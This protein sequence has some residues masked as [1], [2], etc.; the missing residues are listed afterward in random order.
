M[1]C[2]FTVKIFLLLN[3][4]KYAAQED[5]SVVVSYYLL[6]FMQLFLHYLKVIVQQLSMFPYLQS[7]LHASLF[8]YEVLFMS[9][10]FSSKALD[11]IVAHASS[12]SSPCKK[13]T[14]RH[15]DFPFGLVTRMS[16]LHPPTLPLSC[17]T[18]WLMDVWWSAHPWLIIELQLSDFRIHNRHFSFCFKRSRTVW[19]QSNPGCLNG[20]MLLSAQA[21]I[22][23]TAALGCTSAQMIINKMSPRKKVFGVKVLALTP[24]G[25]KIYSG[26]VLLWCSS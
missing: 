4:K 7:K 18:L 19:E 2:L 10:S 14:I 6:F 12:L 23:I 3:K 8:S 17:P 11:P 1:T 13:D 5:I 9:D 15:G 25:R 24:A 16:F 26:G 20:R 22:R 21:P